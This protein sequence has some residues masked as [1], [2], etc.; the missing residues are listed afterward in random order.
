[1]K[2]YLAGPISGQGYNEVMFRYTDM[3]KKFK[4]W[5]YT[6]LYPML[7]KDYLRNEV[8]FKAHG[9]DHPLST[10]H[11]IYER[12][13]WMVRQCDVIYANLC[14][15]GDRV[16]IGTM[17]EIAWG[18]LLGK[19]V[20]IAMQENNIHRHAFVL[21]SGCVVFSTEKDAEVYLKLLG[22]GQ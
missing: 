21:E 5:G 12:D 18:S 8:E 13:Q 15:S 7:G 16:S 1:M 9:Y 10:N 14:S 3:K 2:I 6:V 17:M 19:N 20:V 22:E 11:A 4:S